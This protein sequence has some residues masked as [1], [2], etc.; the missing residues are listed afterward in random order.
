MGSKERAWEKQETE[1]KVCVFVCR[2]GP[3][4]GSEVRNE[5]SEGSAASQQ[6]I[7]R[8]IYEFRKRNFNN[9]FSQHWTRLCASSFKLFCE[10]TPVHSSASV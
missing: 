5:K 2:F 1:E 6:L 3:V 4:C 10:L 9:L 8:H 7:G